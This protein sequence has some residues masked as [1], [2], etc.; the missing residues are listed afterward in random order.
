MA[1]TYKRPCSKGVY[2]CVCERERALYCLQARTESKSGAYC[3]VN[4][5][6]PASRLLSLAER[7]AGYETGWT[8]IL[9]LK[10]VQKMLEETRARDE[11]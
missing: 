9:C 11:L 8:P 1:P 10:G 7:F 2:M 5:I 3:T 6:R 4:V